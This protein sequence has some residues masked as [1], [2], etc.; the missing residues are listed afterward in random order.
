MTVELG[1]QNS[2]SNLTLKCNAYTVFESWRMNRGK[3]PE[4]YLLSERVFLPKASVARNWV[5]RNLKRIQFAIQEE[6]LHAECRARLNNFFLSKLLCI[7]LLFSP[8]L[9][10]NLSWGFEIID[11]FRKNAV[12]NICRYLKRF[13]TYKKINRIFLKFDH[14]LLR[15]QKKT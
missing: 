11:I 10:K 6:Q 1:P 3:L 4:D 5:I 12:L 14:S 13:Y 9:E 8:K 2:W 7:F 15:M